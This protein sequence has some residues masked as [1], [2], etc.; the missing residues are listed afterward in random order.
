MSATITSLQILS[1]SSSS[2]RTIRHYV[3]WATQSVIV[4]LVH[5]VSLD[6]LCGERRMLISIVT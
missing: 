6:S 1:S 3:N 4:L 2:K 5:D